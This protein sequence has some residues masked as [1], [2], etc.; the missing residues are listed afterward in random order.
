MKLDSVIEKNFITLQ[1]DMSL[2][3]MLRSGVSKSSRN[4]FPVVDTNGVLFGI[5][6]LDDIRSVMFDQTLYESTSVETFMSIPP[7]YINYEKDSMHI[8]MKK[9]QDSGAWNL[10]VIKNGKYYGFVSKSKLLTAYRKELISF[11]S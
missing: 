9:F 4:L 11:S 5:I 8:V 10:P 2:G 3:T 1:P 6:L 7:D